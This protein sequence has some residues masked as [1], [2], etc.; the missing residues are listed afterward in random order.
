[1]NRIYL[2]LSWRP[3]HFLVCAM[4]FALLAQ[5]ALGA[6]TFESAT[7]AYGIISGPQRTISIP[8]PSGAAAG[9]LLIASMSVRWYQATITPP[10]GWN[11]VGQL[12]EDTPQP[13]GAGSCN[14]GTTAGIRTLSFY[15]IATAGE[16]APT[17][18]YSSTCNDSG[19]GAAGMLRFSGA[20]TTTPIVASA[21][22]ATGNSTSHT[23]P[24]I[25]S[26]S[27]TNTMLVT[28]HSYGSSRSWTN[29]PSGMT[30]RV[31]QRSYNSNNALGTTLGIYTQSIPGAGA[32]GTRTAQG[33]GDADNGATQ[34]ILIRQLSTMATATTVADYHMDETSWS[35][36]PGEVADSSGQGHHGTAING[37]TN[38]MVGRLCRGASFDGSNDYIDVTNLSDLL[39]DTSSLAFWIKTTQTGNDTDWQA[40]G[41]SGVEQS[42][43]T[44]DIFWGWLD[45]SGR[46]GISVG[47]DQNAKSSS[48]INDD[49]WHHVVL[50]RD[51]SSGDYTIYIDGILDNSGTTGAGIISTAFSSIGRIEDTGGSPEY[52]QGELDEVLIF[53]AVLNSTQVQAGYNSQLAGNN[54]DG[55][56]RI[57][58]STPAI[59]CPAIFPSAV[60]N[61]DSGGE[62]RF[63]WG[64]SVSDPDNA[65]ETQDLNVNGGWDNNADTCITGDCTAT[66]TL[67]AVPIIGTFQ[68]STSNF[69]V[70]TGSQGSFALGSD[71]RSDYDNIYTGGDS[72]ISDSGAYTVYHIDRLR[73]RWSDEWELRG[74]TDYWIERL[75]FQDSDVTIRVVGNG[76]ARVFVRDAVDF[77]SWNMQ[78]NT[79]GSPSK[80]LFAVDDDVD[81]DSGSTL[82]A[83][84]Y[85]TGDVDVSYDSRVVGAIASEGQIRLRGTG[86]PG[87]GQVVYDGAA[88]NA[89]DHRGFCGAVPAGPH[90]LEIRHSSGTGLTCTPSTLTLVACADA[91]CTTLFTQGASGT[92]NYTG[93]ETVNWVGGAPFAIPNGS[94]SITKSVQVTTPGSIVLGATVAEASSATTCNFGVPSCTFTAADAG[95]VVSTPNHIAETASTLT[96]Q[97][98][99]KDDTGTQCVPAFAN[100]SKS[101]NLQCDYSNP[102]DGTLPVR[103]SSTALNGAGDVATACDDIGATITLAFNGNGVATPSLAYA[104]V[105]E[106]QIT[107]S[108]TGANGTTEA[109]LSMV[110]SGNF[111]T[112]PDHFTLASLTCADGTTNPGASDAS[113]AAFC[114]A[115]QNFTATVS[116]RNANDAITPNFG[117]ETAA[118]TVI[119]TT[120][121]VAPTG[122]TNPALNGSFGSFGQDCGGNPDDPGTACGTFSWGEVGIVTLTPAVGDGNYLGAGNTSGT[123]SAN[124]GRFFPASFAVT[125]TPSIACSGTFT[126]AGLAGS[127]VGQPF[128]VDGTITARN[129][130]GTTTANYEGTFAKLGTGGVTAAPMQSTAAAAG[131]LTWNV[132]SLTFTDGVGDMAATARYAFN[133][134]G[135]PQAMHLRVMANDGEATGE[136]NNSGKAVEYRLGRLRLQNAY[137]AELVDIAVPLQAEY[138]DA[139]GYYRLNGADNCTAIRCWTI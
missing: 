40:P 25:S 38:T 59:G 28:V 13:N 26:G 94:S 76:T 19:F 52:F 74:G 99:M 4:A 80:L 68:T 32:T 58:P 120:T 79:S 12:I 104:D 48:S 85:A 86:N 56:A 64:S 53:D 41:I 114:R 62:I 72:V 33:A 111:I 116:A 109:G 42:G 31:D 78:V 110:G 100:V 30:E 71:G 92:M 61:S 81:I 36:S 128:A 43:G 8:I 69:D 7:Q 84:F 136:E 97:A 63:D 9:D 105:G 103:V 1:M 49:S 101:V 14:S 98:V 57:C 29:S 2:K 137:G 27:E 11:A 37:A 95:F 108:Y 138:Y 60:Q 35:G 21:E 70:D 24:S 87:N 6:V 107:A 112:K 23:A 126:Y 102:S 131:V 54:W 115:G 10:A 77:D 50:T 96:L 117:R 65:L 119:L 83:V 20:D 22:A 135:G 93:S 75:E 134:E 133:T 91:G 66:N 113:G 18:T 127:K 129:A 5:P 123:V 89:L 45:A 44:N 118:E 73:L 82:N 51:A 67:S 122:G 88:I 3:V 106:M 55:S 47:N 132:N 139:L 15:K 130:A 34:S 46:I 17:F 121:L 16:S 39:G 90:H 124:V 125:H